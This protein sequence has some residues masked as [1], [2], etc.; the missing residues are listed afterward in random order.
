VGVGEKQQKRLFQ[1]Y[2]QCRATNQK[3]TGLGL[4]IAQRIATLLR[5]QID[6]ESPWV[7]GREKLSENFSACGGKGARFHF[8]VKNCVIHTPKQRMPPH[9]ALA[10]TRKLADGLKILVVDDDMLNR[11][12]M[13]TKLKQSEEF[14]HLEL[15]VYEVRNGNIAV[16]FYVVQDAMN[17]FLDLGIHI[18]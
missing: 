2:Q 14:E 9:A 17:T 4:V 6:I 7:H 18:R 8:S 15:E 16:L 13:S 11:V 1:K 3:G 12:I 10:Q 5:T